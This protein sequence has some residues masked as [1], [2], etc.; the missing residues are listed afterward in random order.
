MKG[1]ALNLRIVVRSKSLY[2]CSG[3]NQNVDAVD[4][5]HLQFFLQVL[6]KADE[7]RLISH[8]ISSSCAPG[9]TASFNPGAR[10]MH[11]F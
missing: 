11:P 5:R 6:F 10:E 2:L 8:L 9:M 1:V 7:I 4:T 3:F